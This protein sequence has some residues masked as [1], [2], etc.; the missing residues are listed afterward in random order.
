MI[1]AKLSG[2]A[3]AR[4][5]SR[6]G[7]GEFAV[8]FTCDRNLYRRFR[9]ALVLGACGI[10]S[11]CERN[12]PYDPVVEAARKRAIAEVEAACPSSEVPSPGYRYKADWGYRNYLYKKYLDPNLPIDS[13]QEM[14]YRE[15]IYKQ[16]AGH[17]YFWHERYPDG[18]IDR[19]DH[20]SSCFYRVKTS[21]GIGVLTI[22]SVIPM[23]FG[24]FRP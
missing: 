7:G 17:I 19:P 6:R 5:K 20:L 15:E 13:D 8:F 1:W 11:G 14:L 22:N 21:D 16:Q 9:L 24:G 12:L 10:L 18:P 23:D 4:R 2:R 3:S